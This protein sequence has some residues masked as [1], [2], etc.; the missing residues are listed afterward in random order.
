MV[1]EP[2]MSVPLWTDELGKLRIGNTRVLLELVIYAF[3]QG[4]TAEAIVDSY[5]TLAL[6]DVYSVLAYYLTHHA[7]VDEYVRQADEAAGRV[8][9]ETEANHSPETL[10]L[11]ARLRAFRDSKQRP[12]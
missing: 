9:R 8:Q 4:E 6:A 2:N 7:E 3:N 12:A 10:A 1:T 11:R 5:P